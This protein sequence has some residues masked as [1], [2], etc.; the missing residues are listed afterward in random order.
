MAVKNIS[1]SNLKKVS[2]AEARYSEA[3]WSLFPSTSGRDD[4]SISIRKMLM[5]HLGER[6]FYY[7]DNVTTEP[8]LS[9][10]SRLPESAVMAVIGANSG[11]SKIILHIDNMLAHLIIDKL[12]GGAGDV[13]ASDRPLSETEA[14]VLQYFV[15]QA[16]ANIWQ[17]CGRNE[18]AH[19]RF[20]K[21][22]YGG[23]AA[24]QNV[25]RKETL[26][27]FSF[28]VGIG[29][30]SGFVRAC[31]PGSMLDRAEFLESSKLDDVELAKRFENLA[32]FN[33][34]RTALWA[35]AGNASLSSKELGALE[36]GDVII[37]DECGIG[38]SD[39]IVSGEVRLKVGRG[40]EGGLSASIEPHGRVLKCILI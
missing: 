22:I 33:F 40:E 11:D 32:R 18:K 35:E 7:I 21:F 6:A 15:M 9:F 8:S 10:I 4:I 17:S 3:A 13:S 24:E 12:L 31:L 36:E 34:I 37:F 19:F 16:L 1:W 26:V 27:I 30:N 5:K 38:M 39:N 20:E 2:E 23:P 25:S 28:K 14:G 29:E